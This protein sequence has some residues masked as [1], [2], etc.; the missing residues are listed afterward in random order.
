MASR[1]LVVP[2]E[3]KVVAAEG[4]GDSLV[5]KGT[6]YH[7]QWVFNGGTMG[8]ASTRTVVAARGMQAQ[9]VQMVAYYKPRWRCWWRWIKYGIPVLVSSVTISGGG[10]STLRSYGNPSGGSA[11]G[12]GGAGNGGSVTQGGDTP[13][14]H[15]PLVKRSG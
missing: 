3:T 2:A 7:R 8:M 9:S 12:S 6:E 10:G 5:S 1:L 15:L 14:T 4:V 11:V 13:Q